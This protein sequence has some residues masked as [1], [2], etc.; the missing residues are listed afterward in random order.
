MK[1]LLKQLT[2]KHAYHTK[3]NYQFYDGK[4]KTKE[5]KVCFKCGK[6]KTETKNDEYIINK[7]RV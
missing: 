2:C 7:V 4:S 6:V 3:G 1:N 5:I